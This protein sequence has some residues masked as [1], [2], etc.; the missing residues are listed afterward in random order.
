M[1][2]ISEQKRQSRR[3]EILDAALACFS[4]DGFHQTGMADIVR[5]SDMSHG[6]VYSYFPSKDAIIEA[7]ADDRHA[8]EAIINSA[9]G[10]AGGPIPA[11]AALVRAYAR[12]LA[13]PAEEPRRRVGVHGWAEALRNRRVRAS[14]VEGIEVPR[15]LITEMIE[16]AQRE[17]SIA[18]DV[19]AEAVARSLVALFQGFALQ[20]VWQETVDIEACVSVVERMLSG[21]APAPERAK[22]RR[23]GKT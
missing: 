10:G 9:T 13:D 5:R 19:N 7:L 20:I 18:K 22:R 12:A 16:R 23:I 17:G 8:R 14:V 15:R 4:E 3:Q 21:L 11:V 2:K 1:P 6:A